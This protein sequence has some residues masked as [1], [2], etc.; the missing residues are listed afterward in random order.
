MVV[1]VE[2]GREEVVANYSKSSDKGSQTK[3]SPS[4]MQPSWDTLILVLLVFL[5]F[6]LLSRQLRDV[7]CMLFLSVL[8]DGHFFSLR[9]D[10]GAAACRSVW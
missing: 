7:G 9:Y 10:S 1:R 5:P 8:C 6:F 4:N 2:L 3:F